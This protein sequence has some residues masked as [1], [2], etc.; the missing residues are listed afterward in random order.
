[1]LL[2]RSS[3]TTYGSIGMDSSASTPL[4]A[5]SVEAGGA[6]AEG[7]AIH[8]EGGLLLTA[9]ELSRADGDGSEDPVLLADAVGARGNEGA[10]GTLR[11][12]A[13]YKTWVSCCGGSCG[14]LGCGGTDGQR[15]LRVHDFPL[16]DSAS[17]ARWAAVL[18]A[19]LAKA[20][21]AAAARGAPPLDELRAAAAAAAADP[22]S[23][24]ARKLLVLIN[25]VS[26]AGA[27]ERTFRDQCEPVLRHAGCEL[28]VVVTQ[29]Q[30]H[31]TEICR[32]ADLGLLAGIV[33][34]GG[35]GLLAEIC[36]GLTS[37]AD[38]P[39]AM[40]T[41]LGVLPGGSGNAVATSLAFAAD[42][43]ASA[44]STGARNAA[45]LIAKGGVRDVDM[46]V[47]WQDPAAAGQPA[48]RRASFLSLEWG[49]IADVDIESER[50]RCCGATRF[51][52][53]TVERIC[54]LR[55][56]RGALSYLPEAADASQGVLV[57]TEP[58]GGGGASAG[59]DAEG[60]AGEGG[61]D[62]EAAAGGEEDG[63]EG[64][65]SAFFEPGGSGLLPPLSE[66]L[67]SSWE[68]IEGH[69]CTVL[70]S[71]MSH[72][73]EDTHTAPGAALDDGLF[74]IL[75]VRDIGRCPLLCGFLQLEDGSHVERDD[76][77]I[78]KTRA[79]RLEPHPDSPGFCAVDGELVPTVASQSE[80]F[81]KVTRF[82]G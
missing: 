71:N 32:E 57:T 33:S 49:V 54:C 40:R 1:M 36:E 23:L 29:R 30:F 60:A 6:P 56:Y 68:R 15:T 3:L 78:I 39:A 43:R 27:A 48:L 38:A 82:F 8:S 58:G 55:D 79:Y 63:E 4:S 59:G 50:Y 5:S 65:R 16:A 52:V 66:P 64:A 21:P 72:I 34:V 14:A 11:V 9:T 25:P 62:V 26:G 2:Q 12:F 19:V 41:P 18:N 80:I 81:P 24:P 10:A 76:M 46:A 44:T 67:P 20:P 75:V 31:A 22:G 7:E 53:S 28:E 70:V 61:G 42:E 13:Y 37:R 73:A 74:H 77:N 51:I 45:F 17:A 47:V 69:F 35:D